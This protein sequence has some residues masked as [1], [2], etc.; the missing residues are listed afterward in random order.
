MP[1][2]S[3]RTAWDFMPRDWTRRADGSWQPPD[4]FVPITQL[5]HAR[6]GSVTPEMERVAQRERHLTAE[7]VRDEVAAGRMVI[8]ANR[9]HLSYGLDPMA[10]GRASQTKIN[11]NMGASPVS[12][13]TDAEV[14]KLRWAERWGA[15]TVM[16]L[17]TGGDLDA[18][19]DAIVKNARV[20]IGTVPIYSMIIGRRIEDLDERTV[21]ESL[22]HQARQGVDYFTI[23]AGV[24]RE[25]LPFVKNRLI[26]SSRAAARCSRSGCC[27][28]AARTSCTRSGTTSAKCC[29]ATT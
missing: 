5:E 10:I 22:E 26:A 20:P 19:R 13:G 9:V 6:L 23:H 7:L 15:D 17:S 12:S 18:T 24:L 21:L 1:P 28:T 4:G 3:P 25:H 29:A 11:A 8:P 14:E 16:D 27:T 2:T